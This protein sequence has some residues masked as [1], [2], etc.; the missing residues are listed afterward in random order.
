[1]ESSIEDSPPQNRRAGSSAGSFASLSHHAKS[2]VGSFSC[3]GNSQAM[4]NREVRE[5]KGLRGK[6]SKY[7]NDASPPP[8]IAG[9]SGTSSAK[10]TISHSE[11]NS[12]HPRETNLS[13]R[14]G[15]K[16]NF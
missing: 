3:T 6:S 8:S 12:N 16:T 2:F 13:F 4:S 7:Q 9:T 14:R 10:R 5:R 15:P 1:M 11:L